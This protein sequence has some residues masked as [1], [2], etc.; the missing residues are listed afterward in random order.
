MQKP[1]NRPWV[2]AHRGAS[3]TLREN[4]LAAFREAFALGSDAAEMDVRVTADGVL[5]VHHDAVV[6]EVGPIIEMD[7][8]DLEE[9]APWV[10]D[11][12]DAVAACAGMW[13][14]LEIKNSPADPDWDES[15]QV[16]HLTVAAISES[17][18]IDR[19][20]VS[21]FNPETIRVVAQALPPIKTG[22]LVDVG[23][24]PITSI[25]SAAAGGHTSIHTYV[26]ALAG[27]RAAEVVDAAHAAGL[28]V[29]V[30]TTD[31]TDE[32]VRLAGAGVDGI[33][34][35][36]PG[37]ARSAFEHRDGDRG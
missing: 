36:V 3:R 26:D 18:S 15:Q 32:M 17:T 21:S 7:R 27:D 13:V 4:T 20:L 23:I 24:D 2:I 6:P 37:D 1:P 14:N 9:A 22:W 11:L 5:V 16:A 12:T 19:F 31:D 33:I 34:T 28:L 8:D 10:P 30:W 25:G 35:N 29:I